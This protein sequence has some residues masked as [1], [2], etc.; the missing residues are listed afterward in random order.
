M[1]DKLKTELN[2]AARSSS[3]SKEAIAMLMV[4]AE[5]RKLNESLSS[6]GNLSEILTDAVNGLSNTLAEHRMYSKG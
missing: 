4:A 6:V 3:S 5:L 2:D 1:I